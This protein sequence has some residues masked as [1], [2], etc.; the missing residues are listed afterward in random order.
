MAGEERLLSLL[1]LLTEREQ[2]D[3]RQ[4]PAPITVDVL[5]VFDS[6]RWIEVQTTTVED[7][8]ESR[9]CFWFSPMRGPGIA[10]TW[11][12]IQNN[13]FG[14]NPGWANRRCYVRVSDRGKAELAE[15]AL[16]SPADKAASIEL[17]GDGPAIVARIKDRA[18]RGDIPNQAPRPYPPTQ[19]ARLCQILTDIANRVKALQDQV[20]ESPVSVNS[21]GSALTAT[22]RAFDGVEQA[23]VSLTELGF[24]QETIGRLKSW[25]G[26][27]MGFYAQLLVSDLAQEDPDSVAETYATLESFLPPGTNA[28]EHEQLQRSRR[29]T[30]DVDVNEFRKFIA[31]LVGHLKSL[32]TTPADEGPSSGVGQGDEAAAPRAA[33][34]GNAERG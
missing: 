23:I 7:S 8:R 25:R 21:H 20:S 24:S 15:A 31:G 14:T 9:V 34:S 6:R 3:T 30:G 17:R 28:K 29:I 33:H 11:D 16:A 2:W 4:L 18:M 19:V 13:Y 22:Q 32:P 5:R 1:R 10:G 26:Q 12:I 27:I